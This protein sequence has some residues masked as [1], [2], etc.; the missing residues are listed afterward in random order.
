MA[1]YTIEVLRET[2][3]TFNAIATA[4][5][6][7]G[8]PV[9][10]AEK[11]DYPG[12][13]AQIDD[14][15]VINQKNA[16]IETLTGQVSSLTTIKNSQDAALLAIYNAIIIKGGSVPNQQDPSTY[17][18]AIIN[19][20]TV[21]PSIFAAYQTQITQLASENTSLSNRNAALQAEIDDLREAG[22]ESGSTIEEL[23]QE[24]SN[25]RIW[26]SDIYTE[27]IDKHIP[28][29][30]V[31]EFVYSTYDNGVHVLPD[32]GATSQIESLEAQITQLQAQIQTLQNQVTSLTS[33]NAALT[34]QV[35]TYQGYFSDIASS[36]Q[37]MGGSVVDASDYA[38]Y[39]DYILTIP[40][41]SSQISTLTG[42]LDDVY[43]AIVAMGYTQGTQGNYADYD[44]YVRAIPTYQS[45][46]TQYESYFADI[47]T[48]ITAKGG[49]V[50]SA[51]A[52]QDFD[53][54]IA[55]IP[56]GSATIT[57]YE[58][59]FADIATAITAKGGTVTSATAYQDFD[60]YI[61]SIPSGQA[62]ASNFE[63][64]LAPQVIGLSGYSSSVADVRNAKDL[65]KGFTKLEDI[66]IKLNLRYCS[67]CT[68]MFDDLTKMGHIPVI[69]N[70][71]N[72]YD[73]DLTLDCTGIR[74]GDL[75]SVSDFANGVATYN[76]TYNRTVILSHST[77]VD[78]TNT[79]AIN[80]L[81]NTRH[82]T[83]V[84]ASTL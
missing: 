69:S 10:S 31:T 35:Q 52:Y 58:S 27:L 11:S 41:G 29:G 53:T 51:T 80:K 47:A 45:T 70:F 26:F 81:R 2:V 65:F 25:M 72:N 57:L 42:Y 28:S 1:E 55:G 71:G 56:N 39:D 84:D 79:T 13:I 74:A 40:T 77:Y 60:D 43:T 48:A 16:Q 64:Y 3:Q 83:V 12:L 66:S 50:V 67:D 4:I 14:S 75:I 8:I 68:G 37:T 59:Y 19:L 24:I 36:I 30:T 46:V 78:S 44:T 6:A 32:Y 9:G 63:T 33:A 17:A 18:P 7:H 73:G 49:T 5:E 34:T 82:F 22:Y 20:S 61:A 23:E 38:S 76:G 21:S 62:V 15:G 54:Y